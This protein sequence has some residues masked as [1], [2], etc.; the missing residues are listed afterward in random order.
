MDS[1]IIV[2]IHKLLQ[3]DVQFRQRFKPVQMGTFV[4]RR[5]PKPLDVNVVQPS[6][7]TVHAVFRCATAKSV[8]KSFASELTS[9]V[10]VEKFRFAVQVERLV[11]TVHAKADVHRVR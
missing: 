10:A 2:P 3:S 7:A 6:S 1:L 9:L 5:P 11:E 4:L 8:Q